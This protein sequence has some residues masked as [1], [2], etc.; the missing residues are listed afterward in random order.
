MKDTIAKIV[1]MDKQARI[2]I[3]EAEIQRS[4]SGKEIERRCREINEKHSENAKKRVEL[5]RLQEEK[6]S[7][8]RW[9]AFSLKSDRI[10]EKLEKSHK[11]NCDKW[12]DEIVGSIIGG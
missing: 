6:L 2:K 5:L 4:N 7:E 11:D 9:K 3:E 10:V 1:E 8:E 12:V